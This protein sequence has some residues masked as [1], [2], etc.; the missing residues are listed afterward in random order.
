M[1]AQHG[2]EGNTV[3][4]ESMLRPAAAAAVLR[5]G[6]ECRR[7]RPQAKQPLVTGAWCVVR[8]CRW[9]P[10]PGSSGLH[11]TILSSQCQ[12]QCGSPLPLPR[13]QA[14][15]QACAAAHESESAREEG[16]S[17]LHSR[18]PASSCRSSR[19]A[20]YRAIHG[21]MRRQRCPQPGPARIAKQQEQRWEGAQQGCSPFHN[22]HHCAVKLP[23]AGPATVDAP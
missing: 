20:G 21:Q 14:G 22:S 9:A 18:R 17:M 15:Q 12:R 23:S 5:Q 19:S 4:A 7:A 16:K 1:L 10:A 13:L 3:A 6:V 8:G 2:R 11:P